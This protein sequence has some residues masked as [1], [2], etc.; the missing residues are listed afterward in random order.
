MKRREVL[1]HLQRHG[2]QLLREGSRHSIYRN[3]ASGRQTAIPR[4]TEIASDLVRKICHDLGV[5]SP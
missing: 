2:C 4:H 5:P 1:R 3:A